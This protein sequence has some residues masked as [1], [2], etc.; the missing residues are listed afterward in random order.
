MMDTYSTLSSTVKV[1]VLQPLD[2]IVI[3][4]FKKFSETNRLDDQIE[5]LE[6]KTKKGNPNQ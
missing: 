2:A 4:S 1:Q 5:H 3:N 6:M